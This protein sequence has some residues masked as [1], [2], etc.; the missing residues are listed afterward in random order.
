MAARQML[1]WGERRAFVPALP[2]SDSAQPAVSA[3]GC[4]PQAE[5]NGNEVAKREARRKAGFVYPRART[6]LL[7]T[8]AVGCRG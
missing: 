4:F 6:P 3:A 5:E 7:T 8:L 2:Y 1:A